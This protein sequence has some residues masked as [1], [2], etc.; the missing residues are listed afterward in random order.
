MAGGNWLK[1]DSPYD[2]RTRGVGDIHVFF[3]E[4]SGIM[5]DGIGRSLLPGSLHCPTWIRFFFSMNSP[6]TK[7]YF[8]VPFLEKDRAKECGARWDP[9]AK[10][11]F[12]S[13]EANR[14]KM[15]LLFQVAPVAPSPAKSRPLMY[16]PPITLVGE[17]RTFGGNDLFVD[18]VPQSCWFTNVRYCIN[19]EDWR[20]LSLLIRARADHKCEIC[21]SPEDPSKKIYLEAHERWAFDAASNTQTLKRLI[22]LCKTCHQTTH[23]GLAR[24]KRKEAKVLAH[25]RKVN[26]WTENQAI[27]HVSD[28]FRVWNARSVRSWDLDLSL[29]TDSGLLVVRPVAKAA[30]TSISDAS[31]A[32]TRPA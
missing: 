20:H 1:P 10:L 31:L 7:V 32:T 18:L 5:G 12:T 26:G 4:S 16:R 17:D 8:S 22:A 13:N 25:I 3:D 27:A 6:F 2:F 28:A 21:S 23:W 24:I 11:W 19:P 9:R 29:I 15:S 14:S 30:R